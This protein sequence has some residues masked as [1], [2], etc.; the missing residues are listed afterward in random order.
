[1]KKD[2]CKDCVSKCEHAGKDREFVCIDGVSCKVENTCEHIIGFSY[3]YEECDIVTLAE[4]KEDIERENALGIKIT[5]A[6]FADNGG[7]FCF[8]RFEF[9][10]RCGQRI[11]W[12]RLKKENGNDKL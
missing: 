9:C 10:P 8:D 12:E 7:N 11:D 2:N 6:D 5:F 1:M 4:I 3:P